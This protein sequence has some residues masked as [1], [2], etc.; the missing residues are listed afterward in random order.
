VTV[1][2]AIA[3]FSAA[4]ST[5]ERRAA[6]AVLLTSKAVHRASK[7][8]GFARGLEALGE[9]GRTALDPVER[10]IAVAL[11]VKLLATL[12]VKNLE[13]L[14]ERNIVG[15]DSP[16][17]A[18]AETL[19]EPEDRRYI[20]LAVRAG[21]PNWGSAWLARAAVGDE[22]DTVRDVAVEGLFAVEGSLTCALARLGEAL[23]RWSPE[24]E[25]P[26]DSVGR[27][28][29][30]VA[31]ALA[32]HVDSLG[33][34]GDGFGE[35]LASLV[36][37]RP[38]PRAIEPSAKVSQ[39]LAEGVLRVIHSAVRF[40]FTAAFEPATYEAVRALRAWFSSLGWNRFASRS[41]TATNVGS[42]IVEALRILARQG[43]GDDQL[44]ITL[45]D[46][47]G[48]E[49]ATRRRIGLSREPGITPEL[50]DWLAG[51]IRAE[52]SAAERRTVE[53]GRQG[54]EL[55]HVA[56]LLRLAQGI[57]RA[58]GAVQ[59]NVIGEL[60]IVAPRLTGSVEDL[61]QRA[62]ILAQE[63]ERLGRQRG[64]R[65]RGERGDML[66]F[67]PV[68]HELSHG[69]RGVRRVRVIEPLVERV[70]SDGSVLVVLK[71]VVEPEL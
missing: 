31:D 8:P 57:R 27:R 6:A 15:R 7:D 34:L 32:A 28:L 40:R 55:A 29:R 42:D 16:E 65:L 24:T 44:L 22:A 4:H 23:T 10:S 30:R 39:D 51:R 17:L 66:E 62:L 41:A 5:S 46:L 61:G 59:E 11:H 37:R 47:F 26:H 12:T 50:R 3:Q 14:A 1:E 20:A 13:R 60:N 43:R 68:E 49:E 2:E 52:Q 69:T 67:S 25:N 71:A 9:A 36:R 38:E 21:A 53:Q 70:R 56:R 19:G 45:E 18:P 58:S 48:E 33:E 54:E 63:V 64:L 35:A